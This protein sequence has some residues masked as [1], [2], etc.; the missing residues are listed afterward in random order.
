MLRPGGTTVFSPRLCIAGILFAV[1]TMGPGV[2]YGLGSLMLRLYVDI[3][4]MP[5]GGINL[6]SKDPRWVG[7]WWLGFLISA[8][9]VLLA[10]SPYF[11]FPRE[12]PRERHELHFRRKVLAG[13]ALIVRKVSALHV[14]APT[15]AP[16]PTIMLPRRLS[17]PEQEPLVLPTVLHSDQHEPRP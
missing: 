2:A 15:Q 9:L 16:D 5:E 6:T 1:T 10:A 3:D 11:F 7:A 17:L 14:P 13:S 12:M 4:R 8:G